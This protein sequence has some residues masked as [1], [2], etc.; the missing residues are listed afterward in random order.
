[1]NDIYLYL[2][3]LAAL[4]PAIIILIVILRRDKK[5]PEPL[6]WIFAAVGFGVLAGLSI[7]FVWSLFLPVITV[8]SYLTA[9]F[10]AFVCAAIPEELMK[11]AFLWILIKRNKHFN[12]LFDGI[13]YAVCIAMGFAGLENIL[14]VLGDDDW[15]MVSISRALLSVPAHYFF[16]VLMGY[17]VSLAIVANRADMPRY[18]LL[19]LVV[20]I[21]AHGIYDTLCFSLSVNEEFASTVLLIFL[22]GFNWL[23]KHVKKLVASHIKADEMVITNTQNRMM[24]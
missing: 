9:A 14:Y 18:V 1:M 5:N 16:A 7:I 3:V 4:A 15:F 17:F 6:K 21:L 23:R 12:E 20:P 24:P 10:D 11:Y 22:L 13:V 8:D 19:G 2:K